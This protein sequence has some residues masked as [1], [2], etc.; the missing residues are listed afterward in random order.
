MKIFNLIQKTPFVLMLIITILLT[1]FN[2]RQYTRLKILIWN[3]PYQSLGNYL[4]ISTGTGFIL[5]YIV[6]SNLANRRT[7][8]F[9]KEIKYK[10]NANNEANDFISN[11]DFEQ[12][13]NNAKSY[14]N[15]FVERDIKDPSPTINAS[16]RII[17]KNSRT[18][19]SPQD[20]QYN[21]SKLSE[22]S[23]NQYYEKVSNYNDNYDI[24]P[25]SNDWEDDSYRN[26]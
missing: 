10:F 9:K 22:E 14:K 17:S 5:S 23:D 15:N 12:E 20:N 13:I 1:I 4:A 16:F 18:K 3:S 7:T 19:E 26:W 2:Q 24:K 25:I 11:N 8:K 6:T 21:S